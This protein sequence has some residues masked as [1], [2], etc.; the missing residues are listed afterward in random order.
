MKNIHKEYIEIGRPV[1]SGHQ[2]IRYCLDCLYD[3]KK[4]ATS[5]DVVAGLTFEE[6]LG[7]LL[8]GRDACDKLR[9]MEE[10]VLF[11]N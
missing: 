2:A 1:V 10:E 9:G 3:D 4:Q 6:L 7:A 11:K 8:L 5:D